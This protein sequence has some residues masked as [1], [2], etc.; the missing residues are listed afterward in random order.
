MTMTSICQWL[1][2]PKITR[3]RNPSRLKNFCWIMVNILQH[4]WIERSVGHK[5]RLPKILPWP[6][7][8]LLAKL[9]K[10][11]E[12]AQQGQKSY[13]DTKR[14]DA[15]DEVGSGVFLMISNIKLKTLGARKLLPQWIGPFELLKNW[16]RSI[17]FRIAKTKGIH[18]VF[19]VFL[20]RPYKTNGRVKPPP[21][22][23]IKNFDTSY[24][25][26]H[27]L[28]HEVRGSHS[29]PIKFYLVRWLGYELEHNSWELESNLNKKYSKII[30]IV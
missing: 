26:E 8:F 7:V 30:R 27:V 17:L 3:G 5:S 23:V 2:S 18:N 19:Y 25:V 1:N 4:L 9:K 11:L 28:Q 21:P 16:R 12:P 20:L 22:P 15:S 13:A 6:W 24:K 10:H 29:R 14:H